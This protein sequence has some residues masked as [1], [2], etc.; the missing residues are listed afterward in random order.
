M[1]ILLDALKKSEAQR[2]L[3]KTPTL[4]TTSAGEEFSAQDNRIW[5]PAI[6][7]LLTAVVIGWIGVAQFHRSEPIV[8]VNATAL[9]SGQNESA[10]DTPEQG[11]SDSNSAT[12]PVKD[13]VVESPPPESTAV[14]G[15]SSYIDVEKE[16]MAQVNNIKSFTAAEKQG[17]VATTA[18]QPLSST[19]TNTSAAASNQRRPESTLPNSSE[20]L[21]PFVAEPI[22][23]WQ[24]PQSLRESLPELRITVLVYSEK[25]EDRFLLI[26]GERVR[27]SDEIGNGLMLEEIQ[28]DRAIFSYRSYRFHVKG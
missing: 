17:A 11:V 24:V 8:E 21:E 20:Q 19:S 4:Q 16:E 22:S 23:F 5:I 18:K 13:F 2:Q 25:P 1:S 12:T 26:N 7:I 14:P 9:D 28:R 3:G 15:K 6:M 10:A 27:E